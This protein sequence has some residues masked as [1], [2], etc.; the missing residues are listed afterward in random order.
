MHPPYQYRKI[1]GFRPSEPLTSEGNKDRKSD[2]VD[3]KV[4]KLLTDDSGSKCLSAHCGAS[5]HQLEMETSS[6][7]QNISASE[8]KGSEFVITNSDSKPL[9]TEACFA[10]SLKQHLNDISMDPLKP[11]QDVASPTKCK[12]ENKPGRVSIIP[13]RVVPQSSPSYTS[14]YIPKSPAFKVSPSPLKTSTFQFPPVR[15]QKFLSEMQITRKSDDPS[16]SGDNVSICIGGSSNGDLKTA[17]VETLFHCS[18]SAESDKTKPLEGGSGREENASSSA[19]TT[20]EAC[21]PQPEK[22]DEMKML[23]RVEASPQTFQNEVKTSIPAQEK[24]KSSV[25]VNIKVEKR[26]LFKK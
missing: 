24:T 18:Q 20:E 19:K 16:S 5:Q 21:L 9:S 3:F 4:E 12:T 17:A 1:P 11:L 25:K 15:P 10:V 6:S 14:I 23:S 7:I 2:G 13:V 8:M 26:K 22:S